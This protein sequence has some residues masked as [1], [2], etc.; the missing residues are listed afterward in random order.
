MEDYG[1]SKRNEISSKKEDLDMLL[2][3]LRDVDACLYVYYM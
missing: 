3:D 2:E 1:F